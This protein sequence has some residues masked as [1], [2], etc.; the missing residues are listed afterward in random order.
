MGLFGPES[1][2]IG[3]GFEGVLLS[4]SPDL[5]FA[6][7]RLVLFEGLETDGPVNITVS[8]QVFLHL[9]TG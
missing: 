8:G 2:V 9:A 4:E 7:I 6:E 3:D 5:D 1:E